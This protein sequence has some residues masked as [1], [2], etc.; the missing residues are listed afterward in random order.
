VTGDHV[1]AV[2][3]VLRFGVNRELSDRPL[4]SVGPRT[5]G[6]DVLAHEGVHR[7]GVISG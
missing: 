4:L 1:L 5:R 7:L 2:G 3:E 6:Y